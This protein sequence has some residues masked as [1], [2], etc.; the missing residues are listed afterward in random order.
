M[1]DDISS[2]PTSEEVNRIHHAPP[3]L[4]VHAFRN[5]NRGVRLVLGEQPNLSGTLNVKTLDHE[6]AAD[7]SDDD[8]LITGFGHPVHDEQCALV[9]P[10]LHRITFDPDVEGRQ[11]VFDQITV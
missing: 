6:L 7:T 2:F 10:R 5:L 8:V 3:H 9:N 11:R 1:A 4:E